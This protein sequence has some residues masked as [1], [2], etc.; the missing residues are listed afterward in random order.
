MLHLRG[1][2]IGD[3]ITFTKFEEG[4]FISETHNDAESGDKSDDG[5]IMPPQLSEEEMDAMD[6]GY[7][8]D[9]DPMS[10]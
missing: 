6:Y 5:S 2:E 8:S 10:T 4:G 7:E 1:G 3:I 9:D